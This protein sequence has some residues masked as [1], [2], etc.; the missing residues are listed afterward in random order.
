MIGRNGMRKAAA[1][2]IF[3]PEV[4]ALAVVLW[5]MTPLS[6][7]PMNDESSS[8]RESHQLFVP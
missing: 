4:N 6:D 5:A 3:S 7:L 8:A 2:R 1:R